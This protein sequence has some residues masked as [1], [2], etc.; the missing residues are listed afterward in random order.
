MLQPEGR[1]AGRGLPPLSGVD[2]LIT[3][4]VQCNGSFVFLFF[5]PLPIND[6]IS[7]ISNFHLYSHREGPFSQHRTQNNLQEDLTM[8]VGQ[9]SVQYSLCRA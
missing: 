3:I 1:A 8:D 7:Y 2:K 5:F 9:I 6:Q 4:N